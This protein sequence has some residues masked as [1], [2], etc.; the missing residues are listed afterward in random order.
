[1]RSTVCRSTNGGPAIASTSRARFARGKSYS[2][3]NANLTTIKFDL[4]ETLPDDSKVMA[5]YATQ[6][7]SPLVE[8]SA[9]AVPHT[10]LHR[11]NELK[12][13]GRE[14]I[15][16]I[17]NRVGDDICHAMEFFDNVKL[18][19]YIK[20]DEWQESPLSRLRLGMVRQCTRFDRLMASSG[21][22]ERT[23]TIR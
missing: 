6:F 17:L 21:P 15:F 10:I 13:Q 12:M 18:G 3:V 11:M 16:Y 1:M 14:M 9:A 7:N 2:S 23:C 8:K 4:P 20:M 22:R 5:K 19:K